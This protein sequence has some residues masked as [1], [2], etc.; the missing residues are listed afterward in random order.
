MKTCNTNIKVKTYV[1]RT[2][3]PSRLTKQCEPPMAYIEPCSPCHNHCCDGLDDDCD[4]QCQKKGIEKTLKT[5]EL[6]CNLSL[7]GHLLELLE[8]IC[9]LK[10]S[11]NNDYLQCLCGDSIPS[12]ATLKLLYELLL[13]LQNSKFIKLITDFQNYPIWYLIYLFPVTHL[14]QDTLKHDLIREKIV[15]QDENGTTYSIFQLLTPKQ[16]YIAYSTN[17]EKPTITYGE[18]LSQLEKLLKLALEAN[19]YSICLTK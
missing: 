6:L 12:E 19:N 11:M 17:L 9:N 15:A 7:K 5:K 13:A 14:Y 10:T 8:I 4:N 16:P 3:S 1:G 18:A 2:L